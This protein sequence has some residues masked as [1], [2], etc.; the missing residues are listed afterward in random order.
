MT[1]FPLPRYFRN[2]ALFR[3]YVIFLLAILAAL[4]TRDLSDAA[5]S[6]A[7]LARLWKVSIIVAFASLITFF[8]VVR[9]AA[10]PMAQTNLAII[11]LLLVW[12]GFAACAIAA[13]NGK[14]P[15]GKFLRVAA[16]LAF[17]DAASSLYLSRST[18]ATEGTEPWWHEMN[19]HHNS[20][21]GAG[22]IQ[23]DRALHP[24]AILGVYPNNRNLMT[25]APVFDSYLVMTNRFQHQMA[26]DPLLS[27]MATGPD[28]MCFSS[29]AVWQTP[30]DFSFD[31]FRQRIHDRAGEPVLV[32]HSPEQM[33]AFSSPGFA[34]AGACAID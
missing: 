13:R 7:A 32:L 4:A 20:A 28:R 2:P 1:S 34:A 3:A 24:P 19:I 8:T 33:V 10:A 31:W 17:V 29:E 30:D 18:V 15:L 23:M 12:C 27:R 9:I 5:I 16:C 6:K 11:Q 25:K 14:L 21:V 26:A 22:S